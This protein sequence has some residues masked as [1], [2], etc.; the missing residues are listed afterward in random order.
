MCRR[1]LMDFCLHR[2]DL[3]LEQ[4]S[5]NEWSHSDINNIKIFQKTTN[6]HGLATK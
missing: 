6:K 1:R 2:Y 4:I 3:L 5:L